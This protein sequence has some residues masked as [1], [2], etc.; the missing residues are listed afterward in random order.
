M[1]P[2]L[3]PAK[4]S[5]SVPSRPICFAH[6]VPLMTKLRKDLKNKLLPAHGQVVTAQAVLNRNGPRPAQ[7]HLSD[8]ILA[9][10]QCSQLPGQSRRRLDRLYVPR[11][12]TVLAPPDFP[13]SGTLCSRPLVSSNSRTMGS[14]WILRTVTRLAASA[15]LFHPRTFLRQFVKK[16]LGL[17]QVLGV[18]A[19]G[20]PAVD[21][22]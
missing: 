21:L 16:R 2:A 17:L 9:P 8:R 14:C 11:E 7:K 12:K 3:A 13:D 6:G 15:C 4:I 5:P 18:K 1:N 10:P 19:L 22:G 20:E